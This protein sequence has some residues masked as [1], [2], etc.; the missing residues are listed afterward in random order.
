MR[1]HKTLRFC[2]LRQAVEQKEQDL[3]LS[4]YALRLALDK[5]NLG[6]IFA[7]IETMTELCDERGA[8]RRELRRS[9]VALI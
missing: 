1:E 3:S 2:L 9:R 4:R 5:Q 7:A 6:A 8:K